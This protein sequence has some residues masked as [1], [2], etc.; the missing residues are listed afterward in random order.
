M[1]RLTIP[2]TRSNFLRTQATLERA[3]EG[4]EM[5]E[6]KRQILLM[7]MMGRAEASRRARQAVHEV[8]ERAWGALQEAAR[9]SG[10][11]RLTRES[12][13]VPQ[14]HNLQVR[15]RSVMG[16]PVPE[17]SFK[18]R[19]TGLCFGLASG[20]AGSDGV[21]KAFREALEPVVQL[22]EVENAV[23]RL[24]REVKRTQRRV[25]ALEKSLI[26]DY[27]DTLKFIGESLDEREREDLVIMKKVKHLRMAA[28]WTQPGP[29]RPGRHDG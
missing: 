16:V 10:G 27:E 15:S 5:L 1:P 7:E 13:A 22:A 24:A 25:N 4:Y 18:A 26:P 20:A 21:I 29:S 8:M 12:A 19:E 23:L 11:D 17:V 3:Q 6:R 14:D 9:A 2:P 28:Q